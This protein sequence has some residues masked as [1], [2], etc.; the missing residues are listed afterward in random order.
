[1]EKK[2]S[3]PNEHLVNNKVADEAIYKNLDF[4]DSPKEYFGLVLNE[5]EKELGNPASLLDIG[6]AN[7]AFLHHAPK[8]FPGT[9]LKG[10]EPIQSL[11][12]L[13]HENLKGVSLF[14]RGIFDEGVAHEIGTSA[15]VTMLGVLYL[16]REPGKVVGRLLDFVEKQGAAFLFSTFNEEPVDVLMNYRRAPKGEWVPAHNLF[17]METMEGICAELG[18][19]CRWVDFSM[20]QPIPKTDDPMRSWTEPFRGNPN[21]LFYGTNTFATMKLL[22]IKKP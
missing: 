16:F 6:C 17:S 15:A 19:S 4:Y 22:V 2:F 8:R 1:M 7:G 3:N 21:H 20:S 12:A 13:A 14:N 18:A 10:L 9:R 5:I 11:A